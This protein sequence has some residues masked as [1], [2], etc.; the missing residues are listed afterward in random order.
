MRDPERRPAAPATGRGQ[1][2]TLGSGPSPGAFAGSGIQFVITILLFVYVGRWLDGKF[3]TSPW[4]LVL[5]AFVGAAAG[6]Y[7]MYRALMAAT[8]RSD[9]G[10][11][12]RGGGG[13]P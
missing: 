5:G 1:R 8:K 13:E 11:D 10:D 4:L 9:S 7:S 2:G 3:G 12:S 6:F